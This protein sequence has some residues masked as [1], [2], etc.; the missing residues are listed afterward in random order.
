MVTLCRE[1]FISST[2]ATLAIPDLY[3]CPEPLARTFQ[4]VEK[5]AV[6]GWS[7][8]EGYLREVSSPLGSSCAAIGR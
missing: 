2:I 3:E 7:C 8:V 4:E 6:D 5:F 1:L